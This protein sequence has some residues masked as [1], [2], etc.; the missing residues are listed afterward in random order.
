MHVN[1]SHLQTVF[2]KELLL[3]KVATTKFIQEKHYVCSRKNI[4]AS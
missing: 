4:S 1:A 3:V 2:G